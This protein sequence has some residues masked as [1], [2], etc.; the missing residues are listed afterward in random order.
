MMAF[1]PMRL[2]AFSSSE[3]ARLMSR[4]S[5]T[6]VALQFPLN[7]LKG[8]NLPFYDYDSLFSRQWLVFLGLVILEAPHGAKSSR[9]GP[10]T[11]NEQPDGIRRAARLHLACQE[12]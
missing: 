3:A 8:Q 10:V 7:S 4:D 12:A 2:C 6:R 1:K 9:R 11:K 5:W